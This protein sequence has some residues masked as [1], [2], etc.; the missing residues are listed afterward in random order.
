[1][2]QATAAAAR[3]ASGPAAAGATRFLVEL[4]TACTAL[5]LYGAEHPAY[6][7]AVASAAGAVD[8]TVARMSITPRGFSPSPPETPA[9]LVQL[10]KRLRAMGL[11]GLTISPGLTA[12]QVHAL[13]VVIEQGDRSSAAAA[14]ANAMVEKIATASGGRVRAAP[15]R[16]DGL[17]LVEGAVAGGGGGT[18]QDDDDPWR[19]MFASAL[20]P[21]ANIAASAEL[22]RTL[23]NALR[24]S[25]LAGNADSAAAAE[26]EPLGEWDAMARAWVKQL[27]RID[28]AQLR[29]AGKDSA[30]EAAGTG[31]GG[32]AAGKS[33]DAVAT[34]LTT[35]SPELCQ[36]LMQEVIA[37]PAVPEPV[38]QALAQRLSPGVVL[39]ALAA[40]DEASGTPSS[41]ALALLRKMSANIPSAS[42]AG[43][44]GAVAE[45]GSRSQM[46]DIAATLECLLR[47][48][49]E[50]QFVPEEYLQRRQE[51]SAHA[52]AAGTARAGEAGKSTANGGSAGE[53]ES[54]DKTVAPAAAV[55]A[56][57]AVAATPLY[58]D[59]AETARHAANLALDVL[60]DAAANAGNAP[61]AELTGTLAFVSDRVAGWVRA[62]QF[63]LAVEAMS[64]AARF[65]DHIDPMVAGAAHALLS[66]ALVADDL[67]EGVAR[68]NGDRSAAVTELADLL[69]H[70]D[71]RALAALL[72]LVKPG[73]GV[74][75]DMIVEAFRTV[76]PGLA[77]PARQRLF[78]A[79]EGA[80]PAALMAVVT[81]MTS[82]DALR[83]VEAIVPHATSPVRAA[84]VNTIF[85][86][87]LR[88]PMPLIE[89]LLRDDEPEIRRRAV[90]KLVTDTDL[91]TAGDILG[92]ASR[93]G[94]YEVDVALWLAELL[95]R[96]RH[97][98]DVRRGWR[99]WMW[100]RRWWVSLLFLNAKK[101]RRAA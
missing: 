62:G 48:N 71:G 93:A 49:R 46:D 23:E 69:R 79:L 65:L 77:E 87:D 16:L 9:E 7:R 54:G 32:V 13:V 11:V 36:R 85:R 24:S 39:G 12:E 31:A 55:A 98:P 73:A 89:H 64:L 40:V 27:S 8:G 99:Q 18:S 51:L 21:H 81:G 57:A 100:S 38:V 15:L 84:L 94:T 37:T 25:G 2:T 5:R 43:T 63:T 4:A 80:P 56:V 30:T 53:T 68:R 83:A 101:T 1:M 96:H 42:A 67:L 90:M 92:A 45:A 6:Q 61:A 66:A 74:A 97:H 59:D 91:A 22:A 10:A 86:R 88:W 20:V 95:R 28:A 82:A 50:Q 41:A 76:L 19:Q 60:A 52:L 78:G 3:S 47:T 33:L 14:K 75:A 29:R 34:F 35:L 72:S 58:P 26:G 17:R 70:G 44:L